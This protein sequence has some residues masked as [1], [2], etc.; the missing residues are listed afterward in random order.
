MHEQLKKDHA[1]Q[2]QIHRLMQADFVEENLIKKLSNMDRKKQ[3]EAA[4]KAER[5]DHFPFR[6]SDTI[7]KFREDLRNMQKQQFL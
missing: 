1:K 4:K 2:E 7:E 6:G 3:E 5:Y